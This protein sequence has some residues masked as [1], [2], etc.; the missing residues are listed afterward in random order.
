MYDIDEQQIRTWWGVF[1]KAQKPTE[2]RLLGKNPYSGYFADIETLIKALKP[3][4]SDSNANYYGTLQAYFT[5]NEINDDLTDDV[6]GEVTVK[7]IEGTQQY[8]VS[9]EGIELDDETNKLDLSI[10]NE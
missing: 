4:L 1:N 3:I 9:I 7:N 2:I 8:I 6:F 5:L 10:I